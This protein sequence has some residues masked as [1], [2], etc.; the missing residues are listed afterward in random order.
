MSKRRQSFTP[1]FKL[2]A[3]ALVTEKGYSVTEACQA[4]G[5]GPTA[6]R[7][8]IKQ[9]EHEQN[10]VVLSGSQAL[11]PEQHQIQ[12]LQKRIQRL[13][14]EKEIPKKGYRALDVGRDQ[15]QALIRSFSDDWPVTQLC[16]LFELPTSTYYDRQKR[17][18]LPDIQRMNE[19]AQVRALFAASQGSAGARTV[20][21]QLAMQGVAMGRYKVTRLMAEA[22]L[23]SRQPGKHRY[24]QARQAHAVVPNRLDRAFDTVQPN[25]VWCGDITYIWTGEQWSYLAVVMD[26]YARRVVGWAM[27]ATVDTTLT[28]RALEMAY[29]LRGR[30]QG[31]MFHSDQGCQYSSLEY[32]Q[33]LWQYRMVQSMSRRGNCWDNA[34]ME[35]LFRSV[36]SE[37]VPKCGYTSLDQAIKDI[38]DYLMSYYNEQRPHCHNGGL[39]PVMREKEAKKLSGNS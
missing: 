5:V 19:R 32:R 9:V 28:L 20:M 25:Q 30:P 27:S 37:W 13:E 17:A 39:T 2:E 18:T 33:R 21:K 36:K 34:P 29:R 4:L 6:L 15:V 16:E 7:R 26:L 38:G 11:T 8:W 12:E 24:K 1:E 31:V 14:M 22:G 35:R 3:V 23:M 10:G